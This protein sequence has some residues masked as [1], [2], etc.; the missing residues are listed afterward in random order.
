MRRVS[1]RPGFTLVELLVVI[2][3]IGIM[4][5]LLLPAVQAAREA[6]RRSSCTNNMRQMGLGVLNFESNYGK[7]PSGGEGTDYSVVP[8]AT[9]FDPSEISVMTAILPFIEQKDIYAQMN[10]KYSYRDIRAPGNQTATKMQIATY[11]CPSNPF[12]DRKD[13]YGYGQTDYFA[14]VYTDIDPATG[15]RNKA[16]RADGALAVPGTPI[17]GIADGCANTIL[18]I[19]D[20]GR[21]FPTVPF[22]SLSKYPDPACSTGNGDPADCL[23]TTNNRTVNRWADPD[24]CG[25]GVSGPPNNTKQFIN[26]NKTPSGG[27]TDCPWST[28]NCG[29]ND[30]PFSFHSGGCNVVL[31]DGSV[32]F[33]GETIDAVI[34]RRLV[35]RSESLPVPAGAW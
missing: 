2:A 34:I 22:Y 10:L 35:T 31:A 12:T 5:A 29:L 25:S 28:N 19:E 9:I 13:P 4:V 18:I 26:N 6:A 23:A 30:E 11:I 15:L 1:D 3:I 7:M 14:T 27:P 8:P 16:L 21:T 33:L 17:A 24:A 32:H 20:T